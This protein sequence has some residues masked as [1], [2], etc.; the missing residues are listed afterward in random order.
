L[1]HSYVEKIELNIN[2]T[3]NERV[4]S[5]TINKI[6]ALLSI[7]QEEDPDAVLLELKKSAIKDHIN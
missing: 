5:I 3:S 1:R 2:W 4:V 7:K 6:Y